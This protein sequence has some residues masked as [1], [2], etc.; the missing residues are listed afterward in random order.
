[1]KS[2][3]HQKANAARKNTKNAGAKPIKRVCKN[4]N[5]LVSARAMRKPCPE[6]GGEGK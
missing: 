3:L 1:M 6:H 5:V 2:K 4:C